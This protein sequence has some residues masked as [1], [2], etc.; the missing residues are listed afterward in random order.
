[1]HGAPAETET[2]GRSLHK[3]PRDSCDRH[4]P[5]HQRL[6]ERW[7]RYARQFKKLDTF[8]G[9]LGKFKSQIASQLIIEPS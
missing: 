2:A 9:F 5:G 4:M 7:R 1:M 6:S 8:G 3:V